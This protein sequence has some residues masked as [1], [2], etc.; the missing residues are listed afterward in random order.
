MY[1][2]IYIIY[3]II[4]Q[5]GITHMTGK[6]WSSVCGVSIVICAITM[7]GRGRKTMAVDG[8]ECPEKRNHGGGDE[9]T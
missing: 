9:Q 2:V 1:Y 7:S 3:I 4:S 5:S 6:K 8:Y